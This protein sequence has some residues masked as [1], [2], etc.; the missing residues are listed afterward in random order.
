MTIS[1]QRALAR[2]FS[3]S[4]TLRGARFGI[5][6]ELAPKDDTDPNVLAAFEKAIQDLKKAGATIIDPFVIPNLKKHLDER[7]FCSRFATYE[8]QKFP[9]NPSSRKCRQLAGDNLRRLRI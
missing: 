1:F 8:R 3:R 5:V 2:S 6:R 4:G 9:H 7:I